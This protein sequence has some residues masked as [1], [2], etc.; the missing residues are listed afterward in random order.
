M[1]CFAF[2]FYCFLRVCIFTFVYFVFSV[3]GAY[4]SVF[5]LKSILLNRYVFRIFLSAPKRNSNTFSVFTQRNI[6]AVIFNE[7]TIVYIF[8]GFLHW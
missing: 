3:C 6:E 4:I 2:H 7:M 5:R 8:V 1:Y